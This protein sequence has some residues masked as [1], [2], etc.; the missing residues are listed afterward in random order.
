MTGFLM[1]LALRYPSAARLLQKTWKFLLGGAIVL[2]LVFSFMWW[3]SN[4]ESEHEQIGFD[5]AEAQFSQAIEEANER[6]RKTQGRLDQMIVAFGALSQQREQAINLTVRPTI[7]RI[8]NEISNDPRYAQCAVSDGVLDDLNA[9]RA[10][11]DQ[12]IRSSSPS[13]D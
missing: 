12:G 9:G 10:A 13:R 11:V 3:K 5:R 7:Q 8:E 2:A 6:E 1:S 4:L